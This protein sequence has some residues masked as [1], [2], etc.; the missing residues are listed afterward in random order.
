MQLGEVNV[1]NLV[2]YSSTPQRIGKH[3]IAVPKGFYKKLY[4]NDQNYTKCLYYKNDNT[5]DTKADKL[6]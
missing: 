4:N 2:E 6:K 3:Q 5:I 1:I